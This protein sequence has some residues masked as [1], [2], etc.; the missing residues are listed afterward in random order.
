MNQ[1]P[2]LEEVSRQLKIEPQILMKIYELESKFNQEI[3]KEV[4]FD[5]RQ[6]LYQFIYT[7]I[8]KLFTEDHTDY[9][10]V[11]VRKKLKIV[12]QFRKELENKSV[13]DIGSGVG[14]FLYALRKSDVQ[15]TEAYGVDIKAAEYPKEEIEQ[16]NIKF[17]QQNI[18]DFKVDR[19][20]DVIMLDNVYEHIAMADQP[21]FF[22]SLKSA[23]K[24]GTKI[25]MILPHRMFGPTDYT[26]IIDN[27]HSGRL[28]A[29]L[30]HLNESSFTEI[31]S[32]LKEQGFGNFKT[33][34]PFI[35][36]Q[37]IRNLFPTMRL[38]ASWFAY[39]ENNKFLMKC[40]YLIHKRNRPLFRMEVLV[41]G[42]YL[43]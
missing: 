4:S 23:V 19:P 7:E 1:F 21:Y 36:F 39:I 40:L 27:T 15:V 33:T 12:K 24:K 28:K 25:I 11:L 8:P 41:V 22:K 31:M 30:V 38:P 9:F 35:A 10:Q 37:A 13:L 14:S 17:Y 18:L 6:E 34:V 26:R 5:K 3:N 32:D 2:Y 43:G 20:F 42:E 29:K 16:L